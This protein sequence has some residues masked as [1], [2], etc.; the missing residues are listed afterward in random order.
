MGN[1][2]TDDSY[3]TETRTIEQKLNIIFDDGL[4]LEVTR[5][6]YLITTSVLEEAH[7]QNGSTPFG[8]VTSN[9]LEIELLNEGGIFTPSNG[10]SPYYGKMLRGV[11]IELYIRPISDEVYEWDKLGVYYVTEWN[12]TVTGLLATVTANDKL[13]N[14]FNKDLTHLPIMRNVTQQEYYNY[15]FMH[16]GTEADIDTSLDT[17]LSYAYINSDIKSALSDLSESAMAD[18]F[19]THAGNIKVL[20]LDKIRPLRA[21]ITDED[22]I[23]EA[24]IEQT[25]SAG[26]DGIEILYNQ[27]FESEP[28][29][30]SSI[31][32]YEI[33]TGTHRLSNLQL[34]K[35]P[36]LRLCYN[37]FKGCIVKITDMVATPVELNFN[38]SNDDSTRKECSLDIYGTTLETNML[39]MGD[40]GN[41]LLSIS[42]FYIQSEELAQAIY[43]KVNAYISNTLPV[44]ELSIRGNPK[45]ELGDIICAKSARYNLNYTGVL[46]KQTFSY[47][48]GLSSN[49]SLL[50]L[51]VLQEV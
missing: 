33:P 32:D 16:L 46:I 18:C 14:I 35:K 24:K 13:Y 15:I 44:L 47:D 41:N 8:G 22:Q 7:S 17:I 38:I 12:A 37:I 10:K 19:C 3:C 25:L 31:K 39:K 20:S 21:T 42:N 23:I 40:D 29:I 26:Y 6:N 5:A 43:A 27:P 50:N 30:V 11:K 9:E 48:G 51:N 36:L 4:V 1:I 45:F 28:Q 2:T 49:I 34:S